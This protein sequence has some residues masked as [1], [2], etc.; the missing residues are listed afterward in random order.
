MFSPLRA[1]ARVIPMGTPLIQIPVGRTVPQTG[2]ESTRPRRPRHV[3]AAA[4]PN[5]PHAPGHATVRLSRPRCPAWPRNQ[6]VAEACGRAKHR[7]ASRQNTCLPRRRS[8]PS[9]GD[10]T[11]GIRLQGSCVTNVGTARLGGAT[12]RALQ[13]GHQRPRGRTP[14]RS[15]K[16]RSSGPRRPSRHGASSTATQPKGGCHFS[17]FFTVVNGLRMPRRHLGL[18]LG[19]GRPV[20]AA[21]RALRGGAPT[22]GPKAGGGWRAG[23][24]SVVHRS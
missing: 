4:H 10:T 18:G 17:V 14:A 22:V 23:F 20:D 9:A 12:L 24:V 15:Q 2:C 8:S 16:G 21:V 13:T 11:M 3:R 7:R 1:C 5:P 6:D 19:R